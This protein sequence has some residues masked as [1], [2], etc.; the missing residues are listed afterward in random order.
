MANRAGRYGA[1]WSSKPPGRAFRNDWAGDAGICQCACAR[2][3]RSPKQSGDAVLLMSAGIG[4]CPASRRP[5]PVNT[6]ASQRSW[7]TLS[8]AASAGSA[9]SAAPNAALRSSSPPY[10]CP[11][12]ADPV[13]T[14]DTPPPPAV[15]HTVAS[16]RYRRLRWPPRRAFRQLRV[17]FPQPTQS[18]LPPFLTHPNTAG[19]L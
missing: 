13:E 16:H 14:T 1:T 7:C 17:S 2:T 12:S 8:S 15:G 11:R 10:L 9:C 5:A 18:M 19:A 6:P 3:R 4:F